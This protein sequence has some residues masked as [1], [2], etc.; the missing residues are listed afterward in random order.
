MDIFSARRDGSR[1]RQLTNSPGYDAEAAYSPDGKLIVFCSLR[2]AYPAD[3][4]SP[5]N[6]KRLEQDPAWFGEIYLMNSDGS[7]PRRL[8]TTP[9]YDGGPFFS[10]DGKRIL[11]RRFEPDGVVAD[12]YSMKLDG[13]DVRRLTR[14]GAM[15]WAPYFHPSGEYVIFAS[16]K[17]GFSNF[18]LY[19]VDAA[20]QREPLRVTHSDGFDGLPVFSPD[21]KK[22]A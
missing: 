16:N 17:L 8:T 3:K 18:E 22:L 12:I 21:G 10:P 1:L 2:D 13:S 7:N 14:F 6:R 9:G 11:W 4:L 5:E 15:S 20:G 19:L